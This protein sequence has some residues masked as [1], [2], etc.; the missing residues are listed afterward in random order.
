M[1]KLKTVL[2]GRPTAHNV[3]KVDCLLRELGVPFE[4]IDIG[5]QVGDLDT[6]A[7]RTLNPQGR[8]PVLQIDGLQ[9]RE[10]NSICRYLAERSG[11][12]AWWPESAATRATIGAWLD[13]ELD[14]WQ[15]A[16]MD[17]FWGFYRRPAA[18]HKQSAIADAAD[19]CVACLAELEQALADKVWLT[20][21]ALSIADIGC[22]VGLHRYLNMGY[23]VDPPPNIQRWY[24]QLAERPAWQATA[25]V[26]FDALFDR[27]TF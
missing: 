14:R 17:L 27:E 12:R 19:R 21:E 22:S 23:P 4:H 10:S 20:G 11:D 6:V 9:L 25:M 13:W 8:I 7:F 24:T 2:W 18:K 16:F 5:S 1:A 3:I 26:P 15:P